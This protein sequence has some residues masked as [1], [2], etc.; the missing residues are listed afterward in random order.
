MLYNKKSARN[1]VRSNPETIFLDSS[2]YSAI[3]PDLL[4]ALLSLCIIISIIKTMQHALPG[5]T[6]ISLFNFN[7]IFF[8]TVNFDFL[9][10]L[11]ANSVF[12]LQAS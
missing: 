2:V 5:T 12:H 7:F 10:V 6:C 8:D 9:S 3:R 1:R 4:A 11:K